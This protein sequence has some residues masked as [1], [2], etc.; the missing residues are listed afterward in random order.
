MSSPKRIPRTEQLQVATSRESGK[1]RGC[2]DDRPDPSDHT[3][4]PAGRVRT[5]DATPPGG[6]TDEPEQA[7]DRRGLAGAVRTEEPEHAALRNLEVE[8]VDGHGPPS[9]Q[10]AVLLAEAF[11][12]DDRA[13]T[14]SLYVGCLQPEHTLAAAE[15]RSR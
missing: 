13:D 11:H 12:L 10:A 9:A 8:T 5:K 1:E 6:G 15:G 7:A 14:D 4:E 2:F 3:R